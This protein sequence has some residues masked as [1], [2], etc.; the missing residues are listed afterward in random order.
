[1]TIQVYVDESGTGGVPQ[2]DSIVLAG[3]IGEAA[4]WVHFSDE[5]RGCL[6]AAPSVALLKMRNAAKLRG[7]FA[8]W[9]KDSRDR[10]VRDL[11]RII[12][13]HKV[14]FIYNRTDLSG[15][16]GTIAAHTGRPLNDPYF[17]P[18]HIMIMSVCYDLLERGQRERFEIIFDESKISGLRAKGWYPVIKDFMEPHEQA[19]MPVEPIFKTDDE[20]MPLQAADMYA[21]LFR[22]GTSKLPHSFD[23]LIDEE[24]NAVPVSEH[25]Q[26]LSRER[27][28]HQ[29]EMSQAI[30]LT[31]E[32]LRRYRE[33]LGIGQR[34]L[35]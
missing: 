30:K 33:M 13:R 21:W 20:S 10:K 31:A 24:L 5:W 26:L 1:M 9:S 7:E 29:V 19:I 11:A 22:R 16:V 6:D 28:Q 15:F 8:G 34:D 27:M 25:S 2:S 32:Q 3:L 14:R 18:F 17:F 35:R 23:W 4:E 12:A